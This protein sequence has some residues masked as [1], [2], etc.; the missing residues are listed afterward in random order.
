MAVS[1]LMY[2]WCQ[3]TQWDVPYCD[4]PGG[5]VSC[6]LW[7]ACAALLRLTLQA[8]IAQSAIV[9]CQYQC[10][11]VSISSTSLGTRAN[12]NRFR[13][14]A[15]LLQRC[16]SPQAN[17]T[18]HDAW[19]SPVL[20][21]YIY[22]FGGSWPLTELPGAKF[23]L[24]PSLALSYIGSVTAQHSSS[25]VSKLCRVVQGMKLWNFR[26]GRHLYSYTRQGGHHV[27]H[28]PTF[29][30]VICCAGLWLPT[31]SRLSCWLKNSTLPSLK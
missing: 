2:A 13:I 8:T 31:E 12:F 26:R 11:S 9:A 3:L 4:G 23:T 16:S 28:R 25:G 14:L 20:V 18:L 5:S 24:R 30:V 27:G 21:H 22:I 15:S 29:L 10:I 1:K 7:L 6:G 19:P 17:Q